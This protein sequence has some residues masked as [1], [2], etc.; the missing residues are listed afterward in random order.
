M[1]EQTWK[2]EVQYTREQ[3]VTRTIVASSADEAQRKMEEYIETFELDSRDDESD[4]GG[5][6]DVISS[7]EPEPS[8]F[9]MMVLGTILR[10]PNTSRFPNPVTLEVCGTPTPIGEA[11]MRIGEIG[12]L[13]EV[14]DLVID[15]IKRLVAS[16]RLALVERF[17]LT[18]L[19][20][21]QRLVGKPGDWVQVDRPVNE[22]NVPSNWDTPIIQP[23]ISG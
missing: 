22:C 12:A 20:N 2:Y 3:R 21:P 13:Y 7:N 8:K 4:D 18:W 1:P 5:I 15:A 9:D 14:Y 23:S 10:N 16:G 17:G 19:V 6:T 11:L